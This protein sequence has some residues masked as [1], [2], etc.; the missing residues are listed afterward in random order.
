MKKV[1]FGKTGEEVS[2]MCLGT[3]MFGR[4]CDEAESA[5]ILSCALDGGV[6]FL[7]TAAMYAEG[8][9]EE[10]IGRSILGRRKEYFITT[11]VHRGL[12]EISITG[13]IEESLKRLRTDYV[14]LYLIHWP[15]E[16]MNP[17]EI[18]RSL[19][20]VVKS[21]KARFVGCSN[22]PAWLVAYSN[23]SAKGN[24]WAELVCNQIPYNLIERGVEVEVLPQALAEEIAI[25]TYRPLVRGLL[26]GKYGTGEPPAKGSRGNTEIMV[27]WLKKYGESLRRLF[28]FSRSRDVTPAQ[29]AISWLRKS[30]AVT[31]PIVGVSSLDQFKKSV[32]AFDFDLAD[33]EYVEVS[34][35]FDSEVKEEAAGEYKNLRRNLFL[36]E[37]R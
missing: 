17:G 21:G 11:K 14:D 20:K 3:M 2:E 34:R 5:G 16:G 33:E 8:K 18:M 25:T 37:E 23:S 36:L 1:I 31:S 24:G 15:K 26:A 30:P 32:K 10:I 28:S 12:D 22:Y 6:N 4:S 19:D 29:V 9:T 35:M 13:S 7:D 27:E